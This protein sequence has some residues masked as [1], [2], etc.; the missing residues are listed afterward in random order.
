MKNTD[1][2]AIYKHIDAIY[3]IISKADNKYDLTR[4]ACDIVGDY[5]SYSATS[6]LE[7]EELIL[8]ALMFDDSYWWKD[9][10]DKIVRKDS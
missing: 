10:N 3:G 8:M 5:P 1:I 7:S 6:N 9:H 2:K 4:K